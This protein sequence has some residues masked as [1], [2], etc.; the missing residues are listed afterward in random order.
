MAISSDVNAT[1][2]TADLGNTASSD[3][4]KSIFLQYDMMDLWTQVEQII[5]NLGGSGDP[6]Q[7]ML[8][9]RDT[10]QYKERFKGNELRKK[11][12]GPDGKPLPEL[13]PAAY[14]QLEQQY[15][16][17]VEQ[18]GLPAGFYDNRSSWEQWIGTDTSPYEVQSRIGTAAQ[19]VATA[20]P[21][22][23]QA[24]KDYYG[25]DDSGIAAYFLDPKQA[26]DTLNNKY[27]AAVAGGAFKN[28]GMNLSKDLAEQIGSNSSNVSN[29]NAYANQIAQDKQQADVLSAV[30]GE[31]LSAEDL[32]RDTFNLAGGADAAKKKGRL[33]SAERAAFSGSSGVSSSSLTGKSASGMI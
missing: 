25:V 3:A 14:I 9:L 16:Q 26:V 10:P 7:I 5:T 32:T 15:K 2:D 18:S 13:T 11:T 23:K 29:A 33:A 20:D 1:A 17:V 30:Y 21:N 22:I 24:L 12:I 27:G 4:I 28:Q 19:A 8:Q 31:S 6:D